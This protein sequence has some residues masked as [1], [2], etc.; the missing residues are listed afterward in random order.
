[1][2]GMKEG[3]KTSEVMAQ[4]VLVVDLFGGKIDAMMKSNANVA[5][6]IESRCIEIHKCVRLVTA[7]TERVG[8]LEKTFEK[9]TG[10]L[11][12]LEAKVTSSST[13]DVS[14][15]GNLIFGKVMAFR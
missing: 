9:V 11:A 6:H 12:K 13:V 4:K 7:T 1:M 3:T 10:G 14:L 2:R 5:E 15:A 8:A